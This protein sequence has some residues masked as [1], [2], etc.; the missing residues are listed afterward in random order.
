[1]AIATAPAYDVSL[2]YRIA[3]EVTSNLFSQIAGKRTVA[4]LGRRT[5]V[6]GGAFGAVIDGYD[7]YQVGRYAAKEL[8]PRAARALPR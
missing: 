3:A 2:D 1:M 6:I 4:T 7:T 5:P 8:R